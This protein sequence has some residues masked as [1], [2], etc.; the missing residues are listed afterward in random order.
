[1]SSLLYL[2]EARPSRLIETLVRSNTQ[3]LAWMRIQC[4]MHKSHRD[5][6]SASHSRLSRRACCSTLTMVA[7][8]KAQTRTKIDNLQLS[9]RRE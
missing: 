7:K 1:M 2:A 9:L 5:L 6:A 3:S 8:R 4:N